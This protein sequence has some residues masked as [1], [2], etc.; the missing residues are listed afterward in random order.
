MIVIPSGKIKCF[1]TNDMNILSNGQIDVLFEKCYQ[2]K[3]GWAFMDGQ[4]EIL[5]KDIKNVLPLTNIVIIHFFQQDASDQKS[6]DKLKTTIEQIRSSDSEILICLIL[7]D[8][9]RT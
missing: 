1:D 2:I 5:L 3:N 4:G 8:S 7:R 9:D 6:V